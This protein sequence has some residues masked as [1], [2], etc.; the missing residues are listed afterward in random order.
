MTPLVGSLGPLGWAY[1]A[2][3]L[4]G[5]FYG[6]FAG[7]F[8]LIG[9]HFGGEVAGGDAPGHTGP[10]ISDMGHEPGTVDTGTHMTPFNPVVISIFLVSFGGTGLAA[11]QLLGWHLA[12]LCVA[13]PSG[14]VMGAV[15]FAFFEK[16]FNITQGSSS[17]S[18]AELIGKDAEVITPIPLDGLGEIA[19]NR[20]GSRFTAAA[21]CE[22][23]AAAPKQAVVTIVRIV[24]H[25]HYVKPAGGN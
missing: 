24:G 15:T 12:S 23:G 3:L 1:L 22:S 13:A 7:L 5:L 9:G 17:P 10:E 21:R 2:C 25:T 20:R 19:Y 6:L 4:L 18:T 16:I 14:L 11:M 8:S